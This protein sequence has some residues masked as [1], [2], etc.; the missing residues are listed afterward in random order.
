VQLP[1]DN[2]DCKS[3]GAILSYK[4]LRLPRIL[5]LHLKRFTPNFEKQRYEKITTPIKLEHLLDLRSFSQFILPT[6][7][8]LTTAIERG[9]VLLHV[10]IIWS[11]SFPAG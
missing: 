5:V 1:C 2:A 10:K 3:E 7:L 8:C 11:H 6:L 4:I 9:R